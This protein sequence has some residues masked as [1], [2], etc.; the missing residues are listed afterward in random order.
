MMGAAAVGEFADALRAQIAEA[1][2]ELAVARATKD[3]D[4][5]T[6]PLLRLR[7]LLDVA[8][9]NGVEVGEVEAPAAIG[10]YLADAAVE[11]CLDPGEDESRAGIAE[12][13]VKE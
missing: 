1:R 10:R 7:Y 6:P 3:I 11:D 9:E 4:A 12:S 8:A 13:D 5:I 2:A